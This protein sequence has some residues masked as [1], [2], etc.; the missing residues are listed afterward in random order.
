MGP[1]NSQNRPLRKPYSLAGAALFAA[2]VIVTNIAPAQ[3]DDAE[4]PQ[5]A[6]CALFTEKGAAMRR[7]ASL[8]STRDGV[9]ASSSMVTAVITAIIRIRLAELF[10]AMIILRSIRPPLP[11]RGGRGGDDG[12]PL[13]GSRRRAA[14]QTRGSA[15]SRLCHR[16]ARGTFRR[17][18]V[19]AAAQL[20]THGERH[21]AP[22][23]H[24]ANATTHPAVAARRA[25]RQAAAM[26]SRTRSDGGPTVVSQ[27]WCTARVA[28]TCSRR[29]ADGVSGNCAVLT[30][31]Q[32]T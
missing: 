29:R 5:H 10:A 20:R 24:T 12:S 28:P 17:P 13:Q 32:I 22:A 8:D 27:S 4:L 25:G 11:L 2:A 6:E 16:G 23:A 7:H 18:P 3:Q 9:R 19:P 15:E 26:R 1:M 21:D 30:S 31:T 14:Q